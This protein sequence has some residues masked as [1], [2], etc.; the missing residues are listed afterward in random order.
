[1][2]RTRLAVLTFGLALA[3]TATA[4]GDDAAEVRALLDKASTA[5]GGA[6]AVAQD[7]G[8]AVSVEG[9]SHGMGMQRPMSGTITSSGPDIGSLIPKPWKVPLKETADPLYLATACG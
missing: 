3:A 1:M 5:H 7:K 9:T 8:P 4:R 2:T 6:Q